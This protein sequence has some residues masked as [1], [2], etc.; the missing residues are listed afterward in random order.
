MSKPITA[1]PFA[2]SRL[3]VGSSARISLRVG[4]QG[5]GDGD[6]LLLAAGKLLRPVAG[7]VADADPLQ[8]LG[9]A[10]LPLAAVLAIEQRHL[11]ILLHGQIVD[12]VEALEDEADMVAAQARSARCSRLPATSSPSSR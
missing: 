11:D 12:Q 1:S 3:P 2:V 6:A 4:D 7:A 8:R 5:A 10:L 9:D